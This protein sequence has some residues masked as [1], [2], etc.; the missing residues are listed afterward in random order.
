[1]TKDK[2]LALY[3]IQES[4]DCVDACTHELIQAHSLSRPNAPA[5][6]AWDGNLTYAELEGLSSLLAQKLATTGVGSG[7]LVPLIFSKSKWPIVAIMAVLKAG[8]AVVPLDASMPEGRIQAVV[9]QLNARFALASEKCAQSYSHM[10]EQVFVVDDN[11]M[12]RLQK[13]ALINSALP[14]S[15]PDDIAFT[16]FTSGTTGLPKGAL[17]QHRN[18]SSSAVASGRAM[19]FDNQSRTLHFT[20]YT[21]DA[22]VLEIIWTLV[23]GGCIC[24]P[25]E[26][27]RMNSL[28]ETMNQMEVTLAFFTPRMLD[29]LPLTRVQTLR[30]IIT[31]GEQPDP[32][33]VHSL[34]DSFRVIV[35]YGP[36]EC[37][38]IASI[39]DCSREVYR[40][41]VL[42]R[43]VGCRFWIVNPDNP[44]ELSPVGQAGE[45][46]IE[47]PIVGSGYHAEKQKTEAVYLRD[48]PR[49][50]R[51]FED[52]ISKFFPMYRTGDLGRYTQDG[53]FYFVGRK[54]NQVKIRGQRVELEEVELHLR[55][56]LS[57]T[58][59]IQ[60]IAMLA[61][62]ADSDNGA[63]S[64]TAFIVV[65][66]DKSVGFLDWEHTDKPAIHTSPTEQK[67]F[68]SL[69]SNGR[70]K[71]ARLVPAY[72]VP[73]IYVPLQSSP[74]TPNG[75]TDRKRLQQLVSMFSRADLGRFQT[76]VQEYQPP[77]SPLEEQ[78]GQL[79][80]SLLGVTKV[81]RQDNF[82]GLGGDS[83][84]AMRLVV[85][86]RKE[87][88]SLTTDKIVINPTLASM[89]E[90]TSLISKGNEQDVT[91]FSLL[92]EN[93]KEEI[94]QEAASQCGVTIADIE[95]AY[96][97]TAQQTFFIDGGINSKLF[98]RQSVHL[99]PRW[100][101]PEK[102]LQTWDEITSTYEILRTRMICR[103]CG[104]GYIQVVMKK[105]ALCSRGDSLEDYLEED[106]KR[107]MGVCEP[108]YRFGVIDDSTLGAKFFVLTVQHA[109]YDAYSLYQL[110]E[111]LDHV[112]HRGYCPA[113]EL[114]YN[115]FIER[116]IQM[117]QHAA[118]AFWKSYLADVD[119][120]PLG[121]V[122]KGH[123]VFADT[124]LQ[125]H[126]SL[127]DYSR[128]TKPISTRLNISLALTISN[129]LDCRDVI[130]ELFSNGRQVD[131]PGI[132][133]LLAP[134]LAAYP[135]RIRVNPQ[136]SVLE[137]IRQTQE[138]S[139]SITTF[140]QFQIENVARINPSLHEICKSAIR[141]NILPFLEPTKAKLRLPLLWGQSAITR[142][143]RLTC[144]ITRDGVGLEAAFDKQLISIDTADELL[145]R[146]ELALQQV[147][148]ADDDQK[149]AD[150]D[151]GGFRTL[152]T[153]ELLESISN[154]SRAVK[155]K[156]LV[157]Q[158]QLSGGNG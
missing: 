66:A 29:M 58:M 125:R 132:E 15:H 86:A 21:F 144:A 131:L 123:S 158:D 138:D 104:S 99:L 73:S 153:S 18:L 38:V 77:C 150:I 55:S 135:L 45:I 61:S 78:L 124:T 42:G 10:F 2:Q 106:H 53:E 70:S 67:A 4:P 33:I 25:S 92:P 22:S 64:L 37:S 19:G 31:G 1:M 62:P 91:P 110:F 59:M 102:F 20:S 60:V 44:D 156:L 43:P 14:V 141:V 101:D 48:P 145:R 149:V 103:P 111:T 7:D 32:G 11:H 148:I 28:V 82:F 83:L 65:G 120:K 129:M 117:D 52:N 69:I 122:P 85:A 51:G 142:S 41:G 130:L 34:N 121:A 76:P 109:G 9:S 151:H 90:V 36:C 12:S 56:C 79:W 3:G 146:W 75:K 133:D 47:G 54:D 50:A 119:T 93:E 107:I 154:K 116:T 39:V 40:P 97:A 27:Q 26:E 74:L 8:A 13:E 81:G 16:L 95:D 126:V 94:L 49:W 136:D 113:P 87:G 63:P 114:K 118:T 127:V 152:T 72:A 98:Q 96:P 6:C 24:V 35:A 71:L 46:V 112:Y 140:D 108:L 30:T 68:A 57:E 105:H 5:I 84:L 134:T 157:S 147:S 100:V 139:G 143:L 23:W 89:A 80:T 88:L 115:R 128:S 137:L 17:I 155:S